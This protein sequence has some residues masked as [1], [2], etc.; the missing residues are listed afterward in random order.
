MRRLTLCLFAAVFALNLSPLAFGQQASFTVPN[1]IRYG[2]TLKDMPGAP[3]SSSTVGVTFAIYRQ[4]EGG[5][6]IWMETQNVSTDSAGNYSVLLGAT[7]SSGLPG[8]LFSQQEQRWLGVQVQGEAEQPRV[9][10]VSVPYAFKAHEA[11]T[12]GGKS[13]T[14]FVLATPVNSSAAGNSAAGQSLTASSTNSSGSS[15]GGSTNASSSGPTNFSGTTTDQVVGVTQ[16]G[17]GAGVIASAPTLGIKGTATDPS[18][19]AYGVQGVATG[20]AGVGLIGTATSTTGFTY[21][22]RGTSSSTSGTGV[23]G[24]D[25][26]TTGSTT[27]VSGYVSSAAGTAGIF[28][29]AAGGNI[30]LGQNNGATRF[31]VDGSGNV[32]GSGNLSGNQLISTVA[33]GTAPLQVASQ[34]QVVN[35][36]ASLLGGFGA[37]GFIQNGTTQQSGASLNVGGTATAAG[38]VAGYNSTAGGTAVYGSATANSGNGYGVYGQSA[39]SSGIGAYGNATA[40]TGSAYGVY[41]RSAS[42]AGVGVFGNATATSGTT[43]GVAGYD[44]STGGYGVYGAALAA[45]GTTYGV[46]G[47]TASTSGQGVYGTATSNTGS[48][49]GVTGVSSSPNGYGVYGNATAASGTPYGVYGTNAGT[50]GAGVFGNATATSGNA[51][52]VGGVTTSTS[53]YGVSGHAVAI[54]GTTYGV[55]GESASPAGYG[56]S[57]ANTATSGET[58]GVAGY[59]ASTTQNAS[60][61]YGQATPGTGATNGVFG[62][63]NSSDTNADGVYGLAASTGGAAN[64]VEGVSHSVSGYGVWGRADTSDSG[65]HSVGVYGYSNTGTGVVGYSNANTGVLGE[66]GFTSVECCTNA[67][68]GQNVATSGHNNGGELTTSSPGGV[69]GIFENTGGGLSILARVNAS[70][71]SFSVDG[72]GNGLFYGG[73]TVNAGGTFGAA[74]QINGDLSITGTLSKGGGSFKIDDPL[75]PENKY[76]SHSFVESPDMMNIYNGIVH[77]DARGEAW[78]DLPQYFEALNRDFR[79]QLTSVGAPQPRL[80]IAREVKANRFKIAG[81]KP[82]AKASWQVTGIRQDAWANAHRIPNEE[83]KPLAERGTYLHPDAF[84]A[85]KDKKTNAMLQH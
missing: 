42:N 65:G 20:T 23:R 45:T 54:S 9:M 14:D 19:T 70:Q 25:N 56:V 61:V 58:F 11:E 24:I 2:G 34:T 28:N 80:Y 4:Q 37:G 51:A 52:G 30:L 29:N 36:N 35:L 22:L 49:S 40:A 31:S 82:N 74:V 7:T 43:S 21:G 39:S 12:L 72:G 71:N 13:V 60:G 41:G 46:Y 5:A 48:T 33:F 44:S 84:G 78:V 8:D 85:A 32:T 81:G 57:G 73:L 55:Y 27:G 59:T 10:M 68:F 62:L 75:D 83:D 18:A 15:I 16:S 47:T 38:G 79:Y 53:G 26:A 1:L 76:L 3:L 67:V 17:T 64:G 50:A 69:G 66:A 6:A 63:T 77:L